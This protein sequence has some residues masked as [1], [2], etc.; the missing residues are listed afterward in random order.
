MSMVVNSSP[1]N[2]EQ[3]KKTPFNTPALPITTNY[4][5][6]QF[7]EVHISVSVCPFVLRLFV[8]SVR[9]NMFTEK[10]YLGVRPLQV[11]DEF[12]ALQEFVGALGRVCGV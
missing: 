10:D 9:G 8:T 11:F 4:I 5:K 7:P 2:T 12:V 6:L 1:E 3:V